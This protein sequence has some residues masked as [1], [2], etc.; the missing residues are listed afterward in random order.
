LPVAIA[1]VLGGCHIDFSGLSDLFDSTATYLD[2]PGRRVA[3]GHFSR[4]SVDGTDTAGA[5]V[6]AKEP[7]NGALRLAIFPFAGGNGC[8]TGRADLYQTSPFGPR[9]SL[10][11]FISFVEKVREPKFSRGKGGGLLRAASGGNAYLLH[12]VNPHCQEPLSPLDD[13]NF[14]I[15]VPGGLQGYLALS[16]SGNLV[17]FEPWAPKETVIASGV[18]GTTLTEDKI[19]SIESGQLVVRNFAFDVLGQFGT[20]VKEFDV[21]DSTITRAAFID[22]A[23]LFTVTDKLETPTQVASDACSAGPAAKDHLVGRKKF[24]PSGWRGMGVSYY[25]PCKILSDGTRAPDDSRSLVLYGSAHRSDKGPG[26][27]D[28]EYALG[29]GAVGDPLIGYSGD[30]AFAF[31]VTNTTPPALYGSAL[32]KLPEHIADQPEIRSNAPAVSLVGSEWQARVDFPGGTGTVGRLIRW[33]SAASVREL[34]RGLEEMDSPLAIVNYDGKLGDLVRIDDAGVSRIL[35]RG[36]PR[37]GIVSD[38]NGLAAIS[39]SDGSAGTLIVAPPDSTAFEKVAKGVHVGTFQ[40]IQNLRAVAYLRDFDS[41]AG[42]GTL[43]VRVIE[44]GDTFDVGVRAS[45]WQEVG[46]PQPGI[47]YVVPDG[48]R[49]GIWFAQLK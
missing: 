43:G 25:T 33:K 5:Y 31:F 39:D 47:L 21:V 9:S 27:T 1:M 19:W 44:T 40:F 41:K 30:D 29:G 22:G 11:P 6:T 2:L 23:D 10:P 17:F 36:V 46:W 13:K 15:D 8:R 35:A 24:F 18:S 28:Q 49:A 48:D 20:D 45:E 34:A 26:V 37:Q 32:G 42:A 38:T 7:Y 12:L 3:A 16:D 14:P 4:V